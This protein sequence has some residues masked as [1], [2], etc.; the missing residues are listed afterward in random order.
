MPGLR[1]GARPDTH[2]KRQLIAKRRQLR[3]VRFLIGARRIKLQERVRLIV[4]TRARTLDKFLG[5]SRLQE[6]CAFVLIRADDERHIVLLAL[7]EY[8]SDVFWDE[9]SIDHRS[10]TAAAFEQVFCG[11]RAEI[12]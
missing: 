3:R 7:G 4:E 5:R 6:E 10:A 11:Y 8:R 9:P 1:L 12:F 2:D